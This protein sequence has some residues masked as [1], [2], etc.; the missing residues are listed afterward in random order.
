MNTKLTTDQMNE[1]AA[2]LEEYAD[3]F[4]DKPGSTNLVEHIISLISEDPIRLKPYPVPFSVRDTIKYEIQE[5]L[6]LNVKPVVLVPKRDGGTRFCIDYWRLSKLTVFDPKPMNQRE[7]IFA[8]LKTDRCY[9]MIDLSK[10]YWLIGINEEDKL[11][12]AFTTPDQDNFHFVK[13]RFGLVNSAATF[14]R[15]MRKLLKLLNY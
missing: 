1:L 7:D 11:K 3:V 8:K 6:N 14:T 5:M 9:S 4:S 15:M 12:T 2:L 10:G 13:M